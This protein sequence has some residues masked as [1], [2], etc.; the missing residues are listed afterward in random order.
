[1]VDLDRF[2]RGEEP[3]LRL[4]G[5]IASRAGSVYL[6]SRKENT[7]QI[8]CYPLMSLEVV[9]LQQITKFDEIAHTAE[10]S[11]ERGRSPPHEQF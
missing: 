5:S 2:V 10:R 7:R 3:Q 8:H 1:M 6:I 4:R 11:N 9:T